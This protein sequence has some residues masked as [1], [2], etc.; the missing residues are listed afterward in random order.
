MFYKMTFCLI[1]SSFSIYSTALLFFVLF[2]F[3]LLPLPPP[4]LPLP[5]FNRPYHH[6]QRKMNLQFG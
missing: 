6:H 1:K 4:L 2:C 5:P 3:H